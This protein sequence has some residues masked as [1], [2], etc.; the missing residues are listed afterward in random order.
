MALPERVEP[1]QL[2]YAIEK[3][4]EYLAR[5]ATKPYVLK[6]GEKFTPITRAVAIYALGSDVFRRE[7]YDRQT[8][9][10][11]WADYG[12][13][14][15]LDVI[16]RIG[17][18]APKAKEGIEIEGEMA[19][20]DRIG[21]EAR[22][23]TFTDKKKSKAWTIADRAREN[24]Q[25]ATHGHPHERRFERLVEMEI[26]NI[27]FLRHG[28]ENIKRWIQLPFIESWTHDLDQAITEQRNIEDGTNLR[29]KAAHGEA[30]AVI[31]WLLLPVLE[32]AGE[33]SRPEA[34][35]LTVGV[36]VADM[37]HDKPE[38]IQK[39]LT[40]L[41]TAADL[42]ENPE[43]LM[44]AWEKG[45]VNIFSFTLKDLMIVLRLGKTRAGFVT[46]KTPN[47]L[48]PATDEVYRKQL[49]VMGEDDSQTFAERLRFKD[50]NDK[51]AFL[52]TL[53]V[54]E[55]ADLLD[56]L[57]PPGESLLRKLLTPLNE[58]RPLIRNTGVENFMD[59]VFTGPGN[60]AAKEDSF[61]RRA[62]WEIFHTFNFLERSTVGQDPFIQ[63]LFYSLFRGSLVFFQGIIPALMQ[64][65]TGRIKE[66][67]QARGDKLRLKAARR[68]HNAA[69]G[70]RLPVIEADLVKEQ[71][72]VEAILQAM[73]IANSS[74]KYG[75]RD[76]DF[77]LECIQAM[78]KHIPFP[79]N[80]VPVN[81][82]YLSWDSLGSIRPKIV[83][84]E[85]VIYG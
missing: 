85:G 24:P 4:F 3:G 6:T 84:E 51:Q 32:K 37:L 9:T 10:W 72:A 13:N 62:M 23:L 50:E 83:H 49:K 60:L 20:A 7:T 39:R 67:Y 45:A 33:F 71:R 75:Q 40:S 68:H 61:F 52:H 59:S 1:K 19:L 53:V 8:R 35:R 30:G 41:V 21:N 82:P 14:S 69:V 46:E 17:K 11:S 57:I 70:Q 58:S 54:G 55:V 78:E 18:I 66:I 12:I 31:A 44:S 76:R 22:L 25:V 2:P 48:Y 47:G 36:M 28:P 74:G 63:N 77:V 80:F 34:V 64:K 73:P 43:A 81:L 15:F 26:M 38:L 27:G 5:I 56:M 79:M 29:T 65:D 42:R 16:T